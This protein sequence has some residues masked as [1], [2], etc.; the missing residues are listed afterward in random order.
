[1]SLAALAATL[2]GSTSLAGDGPQGLSR[3]EAA[4]QLLD[5]RTEAAETTPLLLRPEALPVPLDTMPFWTT[6]E[7]DIYSTGMIWRDCNLDGYIDV[8]FSNGNDIVLAPNNIYL[9]FN[10]LL[11]PA[12]SW[13][14]DESEYSGHCG[15]GDIDDDGYPDFAVAN[16]LGS[17]GFS[18]ANQSPLYLNQGSLPSTSADWVTPDSMRSFSCALGDVDND[19]D[20]DIAYA[21]GEGYYAH[22][23]LD[24]I[25]VNEGGIFQDS[26][27]WE[28]GLATQSLDVAWGDVDNDG[29]LDLA[30]TYD[31]SATAVYYNNGGSV[32]ATP[33]WTASTI[34]SGNT[35]LF[36]DINGD[37]W[38]DLV[39]AYNDQLGGGGYFKVYYNDGSGNLDPEYGWR[40][41]DGGYGSALALYDYD[42]D[43]DD[44]LA[45][46]RWF[47]V[48][49]VYENLGDSLTSNP[50]WASEIDMVSEELAWI[51]IDGGGVQPMADTV[52]ASGGRKLFYTQHHPLQAIDSVVSDG[53]PLTDTDYCYDLVSGW[54]SL[55]SAPSS[56][57]AIYYQY[58]FLNDLTVANWDT[59]NMAFANNAIDMSV[60]DGFGPVSLEAHFTN[61][62]ALTGTWLWEFGDGDSS[63]L[64]NPVHT[65]T[66]PGY[67][68]VTLTVGLAQQEP[69]RVFAGAVSAYADTLIFENSAFE[70]GIG[71]V[72]VYAR[73]YLPINELSFAFTW[74][75][76][77]PM[78]LDSVSKTGFRTEYFSNLNIPAYDGGGKRAAVRLATSVGQ[79]YL[80]PGA[81]PVVSL[82][83]TDSGGVASGDNPVAFTS[84]GPYGREFHSYAGDYQPVGVDGSLSFSCCQ[85]PTVGDADCSGAVDI[86]DIQVMVD[87]QFLTL[88]PLCCDEEGDTDLN[89]VVDITDLQV[90]ID[91]QFLT[92]TPLPPCP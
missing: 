61:N 52:A 72:D 40:S 84:L 6:S 34:E 89:G 26:S 54:V 62:S 12:A 65:Y 51:D 38:L 11:P 44:D 37:D 22:S 88:A 67:Y 31:A 8:F 16:F 35:V 64:E 19:G 76:D 41:S 80:D 43:G 87:N 81:G 24:R 10:G 36:G 32:E 3:I 91:N 74:T 18:T 56:E 5:Q 53:V 85:P 27:S 57:V 2:C 21:T 75:G 83:F 79:P 23:E 48:L 69:S 92:L 63:S 42:S 77:I 68:A 14:S 45:A 66:E 78:R 50:V 17:G 9:S 49:W 59:V 15:V 7:Q 58:S 33:S 28:S 29:D 90:L 20:L 86:T 4:R 30:F 82:F 47:H 25:Y 1:M 55:A 60:A 39:V 13:Y 46:G 70:S 73:N 71:R